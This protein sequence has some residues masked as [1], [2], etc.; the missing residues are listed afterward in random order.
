M[1]QFEQKLKAALGM[2]LPYI[3][4]LNWGEPQ[5]QAAV[6]VLFGLNQEKDPSLLYIRRAEN[7][8]PHSGQMAFPGGKVES[9]DGGDLIRTALRETD[10]EVGISAQQVRVLGRLP[11]IVTPSGFKITPVVGLLEA[12]PEDLVFRIDPLEVAE[13]LWV[14][15][16]DLV[17]VESYRRESIRV[18]AVD[19]P[20]DVFQLG[21][22][23]IWGATG[24]VTKNLID[25]FRL[26]AY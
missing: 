22:Y 24:S 6:L 20:I 10:E 3:H 9:F 7:T 26:Q 12:R 14:P 16:S 2:E 11:E 25:R 17:S 1:N 5:A 15:F 4:R 21:N 19:Y 23:R 13:T 8:G 18:G